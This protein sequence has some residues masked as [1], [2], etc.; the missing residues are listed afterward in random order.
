MTTF[1]PSKKLGFLELETQMQA[2]SKGVKAIW[3]HLFDGASH[4]LIY[5]L[6]DKT[7]RS[8]HDV[9]TILKEVY[10]IIKKPALV[11]K[12][13]NKTTTKNQSIFWWALSQKEIIKC[14]RFLVD[15]IF[16]KTWKISPWV[17]KFFAVL[18]I[19]GNKRI[20]DFYIHTETF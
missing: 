18:E 8:K 10:I 5:I 17:E 6:F 16:G 9:N 11:K 20:A 3:V 19:L 14:T 7:R 2:G 13:K 4:S 12:T 1:L 15:I